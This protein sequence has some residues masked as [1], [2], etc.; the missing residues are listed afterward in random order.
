LPALSSVWH[1]SGAV[2]F[3]SW[4]FGVAYPRSVFYAN[5]SGLRIGKPAA[6]LL[7]SSAGCFFHGFALRGLQEFSRPRV[8]PANERESS[9]R[10]NHRRRRKQTDAESWTAEGQSGTGKTMGVT[11]FSISAPKAT[12]HCPTSAAEGIIPTLEERIE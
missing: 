5:Q 1:G 11:R 6:T 12:G 7:A 4:L 9:P 10:R 2:N 8:K 3:M